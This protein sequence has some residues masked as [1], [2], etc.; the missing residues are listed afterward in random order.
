MEADITKVLLVSKDSKLSSQIKSVLIAPLFAVTEINDFN[1]ARRH[2]ME[3]S[4]KLILVDFG[5]GSGLDFSTDISETPSTILLLIP[6]EHFDQISYKVEPYGVLPITKPFDQYYFYNIIKIS[7]AV[8][9][10]ID[11][12]LFQNIKLKN[13]LEEIRLVNRAKMLL[14]SHKN[15]TEEEAHRYIEQTAMNRCIK[16][17]DLADEIIK[18]RI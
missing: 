2:L 13:K 1:E 9:A 11:R 18:G 3:E 7:L 10:K 15:M 6:N 4:F 17:I 14:M 5:D 12:L 8:Q 16:K